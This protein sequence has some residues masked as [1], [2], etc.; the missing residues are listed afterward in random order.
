[1]RAFPPGE[2]GV[3]KLTLRHQRL[4]DALLHGT[5]VISDVV[6]CGDRGQPPSPSGLYSIH[7]WVRASVHLH[8]IRGCMICGTGM[9]RSC[10][11]RIMR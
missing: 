1:M 9:P 6:F 7:Q 11:T 5:M 10:C 4:D 3:G 2:T 8:G